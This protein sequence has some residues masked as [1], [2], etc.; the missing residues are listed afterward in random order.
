[1]LDNVATRKACTLKQIKFFWFIAIKNF[2]LMKFNRSAVLDETCWRQKSSA[3]AQRGGIEIL[4][5]SI[6]WSMFIG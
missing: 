2:C 5:V 1:M 6:K 4:N 3:G